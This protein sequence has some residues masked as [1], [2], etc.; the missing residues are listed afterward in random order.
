[1]KSETNH[2]YFQDILKRHKFIIQNALLMSGN[3]MINLTSTRGIRKLI[4]V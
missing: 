2:F 1:M 3:N 4:S